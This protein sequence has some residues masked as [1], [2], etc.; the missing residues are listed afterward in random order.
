MDSALFISHPNV[1]PLLRA[2]LWELL[3]LK[4][5]VIKNPP[6]LSVEQAGSQDWKGRIGDL[7]SRQTQSLER[8]VQ[9]S[10]EAV[11][12][13]SGLG[14][15]EGSWE[16]GDQVKMENVAG[17]IKVQTRIYE[18]QK[19]NL[20]SEYHEQRQDSAI[21]WRFWGGGRERFLNRSLSSPLLYLYTSWELY[22]FHCTRT[23]IFTLLCSILPTCASILLAS[24][25]AACSYQCQ[26]GLAQASQFTLSSL[27]PSLSFFVCSNL[28]GWW[29]NALN[30]KGSYFWCFFSLLERTND[31]VDSQS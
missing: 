4:M 12:Q 22:I 6:E 13:V 9:K 8:K 16:K 23:S 28:S 19:I 30:S 18:R 5:Q 14:G 29:P 27:S 25:L 15:V 10:V 11:R 2:K 20:E 26:H 31:A 21:F 24:C 7:S 3:T 1:S 17:W